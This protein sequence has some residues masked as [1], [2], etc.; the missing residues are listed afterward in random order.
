[1]RRAALPLLALTLLTSCKSIGDIAGV[2]AA[3]G[4]GSASANPAV[5]IAVGIA[6]RSAVDMLVDYIVRRRHG[7]E[8]DA[9]ATTAGAIPI[10]TTHAWVIHHTIPIGDEHGE[11]E[12]VR[13]FTTPLT[14]C[15]E[16]AFTVVDGKQR[17]LLTTT[18][19]RDGPV[20]RWAQA[21]P[22]VARWGFLQ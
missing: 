7:A 2:A 12:P 5:G 16:I 11:L 3:A 19:C 8:Q 13:E 15:R 9:I 10:G 14:T 6:A 20:W 18:L 17:T 4:S 1:V 21:E 22:A